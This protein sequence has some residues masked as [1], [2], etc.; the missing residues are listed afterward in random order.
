M[1]NLAFFLPIT[2]ENIKSAHEKITE[3][4]KEIQ[5]AKRVRKNRQGKPRLF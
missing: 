1:L 4:K 5:R 2:E 3:C